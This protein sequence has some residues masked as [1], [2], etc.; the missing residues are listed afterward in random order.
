PRLSHLPSAPN[1]LFAFSNPIHLPGMEPETRRWFLSLNDDFAPDVVFVNTLRKVHDLDDKDSLAVKTVYGA[2][3]DLFPGAALVFVHHEKKS[4][5]DPK[6]QR[7]EDEAFSGSQHWID[8]AQTALQMQRGEDDRHFSLHNQKSQATRKVRPLYLTLEAGAVLRCK[9]YED[10]VR[11]YEIMHG[12][13]GE[14]ERRHVAL[15]EERKFPG[16]RAW[17]EHLEGEEE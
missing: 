9:V 7:I 4:S 6:M 1:V 14:A 3:H 17:L 15:V 8:D 10:L 16:S 11:T 2:F 5:P 12:V 13:D